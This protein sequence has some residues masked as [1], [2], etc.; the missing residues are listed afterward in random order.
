MPIEEFE[1]KRPKVSP[2]SWIHPSAYIIGDV[3]IGDYTGIWHYVVIRGD[4]DKITI[5]KET[6][7]QENT[8]IHTDAGTK[9][10][11]GDRVTIGHNCIIHGAKVGS[12]TIIGMGAI[13]LNNAK[14]GEYSIIGAGAVVT[15][16]T[17]IPPHSLALG[18]PAK[19]VRKLKDEDIKMIE[20]NAEI[21]LNYTKKFLNMKHK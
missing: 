15:Q 5:G 4:E 12:H 14:I 21:Y 6:N 18:V 8:V 9:A 19:V 7:I 16:N 20:E 10:E 13:L 11:I 1:G 3:E 2:L 17:E